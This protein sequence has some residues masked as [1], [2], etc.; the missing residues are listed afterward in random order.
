MEDDSNEHRAVAGNGLLD[1]RY[2]LKAGVAGSAALLTA[3]AGAGQREAWM[4]GPG[5]PMSDSSAPSRYEAHVT[6][7][8][9]ASQPGTR[10]SGASRT[11][12]EHLDGLITPNHLH[13]ERHHSGIP[14]I[15]PDQ[16]RLFIHGLVERPLA[17]SLDALARYPTVSRIQFLECSGNS[18]ALVAPQ[19][20]M[21]ATG[22]A[23]KSM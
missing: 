8:G 3:R 7:T 19:P 21:F 11:P 17:F 18:G 16:H 14:D 6:R 22:T 9:V 2:L 20:V 1:R 13:F 15:D 23:A 12:L 5:A 10:G 4:Q